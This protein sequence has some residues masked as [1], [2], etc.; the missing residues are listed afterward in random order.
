MTFV[1]P[2]GYCNELLCEQ[3]SDPR[4][5]MLIYSSPSMSVE[6]CGQT[7]S[8]TPNSIQGFPHLRPN[9]AFENPRPG[10]EAD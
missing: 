10:G 7:D 8:P 1:G 4:T 2:F 5:K 3:F 6:D 9:R